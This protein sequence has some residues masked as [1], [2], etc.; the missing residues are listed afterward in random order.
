MSHL[1]FVSF[2][3]CYLSW[4][5][6]SIFYSSSSCILLVCLYIFI[7]GYFSFCFKIILTSL[8]YHCTSNKNIFSHVSY[9]NFLTVYLYFSHL[10]LCFCFHIFH[11][12]ICYKFHNRML[13]LLLNNNLLGYLIRKTLLSLAIC[14]QF[15]VLFISLCW[16]WFLLVSFSV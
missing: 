4:P 1:F 3:L 9:K 15:L 5:E 13:F 14:L 16:S 11:F 8:T 7:L 6:L 12:F 2:S 10:V